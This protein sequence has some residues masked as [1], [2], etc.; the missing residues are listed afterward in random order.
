M[1]RLT[2]FVVQLNGIE[3]STSTHAKKTRNVSELKTTCEFSDLQQTKNREAKRTVRTVSETRYGRISGIGYCVTS[4]ARRLTATSAPKG[5]QDVAQCSARLTTDSWPG[6]PN[7]Q[8]SGL[9]QRRMSAWD[10]S[11]HFG[12]RQTTSGLPPETD[13]VRAARHVSKVPG[14]DMNHA[15]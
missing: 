11:R 14:G 7:L 5:L 12:R 15:T 3:C 8:I 13:I 6:Y 10:Q 1:S 9:G 4:V 2:F